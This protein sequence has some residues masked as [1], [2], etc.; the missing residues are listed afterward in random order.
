MFTVGS[1]LAT[2]LEA[3]NLVINKSN[4]TIISLLQQ[5]FERF[6]NAF[7]IFRQKGTLGGG[8]GGGC[9]NNSNM[10]E[11]TG[12]LV[13]EDPIFKIDTTILNFGG[14]CYINSTTSPYDFDG[15]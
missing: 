15:D 4:R 3:N 13:Y 8:C 11:I 7:K 9:H 10:T 14:Y 2:T 12:I 5:I 1:T 6:P